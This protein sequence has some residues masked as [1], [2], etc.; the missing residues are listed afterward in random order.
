MAIGTPFTCTPAPAGMRMYRCTVNVARLDP[1]AVLGVDA[2]SHLRRFDLEFL[3]LHKVAR[4]ECR[5]RAEL[6]RAG[7][8]KLFGSSR[9][10]RRKRSASFSSYVP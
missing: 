1:L 6:L 7:F 3:R 8:L 5:V 10:A 2:N 9:P 4:A